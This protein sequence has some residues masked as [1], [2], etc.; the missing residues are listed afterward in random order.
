[1]LVAARQRECSLFLNQL[2]K[3]TFIDWEFTAAYYADEGKNVIIKYVRKAV[4]IISRMFMSRDNCNILGY[5][6]NL[7]LK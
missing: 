2:R 7:I 5:S 3:F 6:S 1:M 4:R